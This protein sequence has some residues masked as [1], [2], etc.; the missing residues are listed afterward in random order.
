[1]KKG[2]IYLGLLPMLG[3]CS[4]SK[5]EESKEKTILVATAGDIKPFDYEENGEITGYDAEVLKAVDKKLPDYRI[6]FKRTSWESIFPGLDADHYQAAANN[7]SYTKERADKYL[8]SLPIAKNPLVLVSKSSSGIVK[9]EDIAGK[10]TQDDTGTS[11]AKLVTDWNEEHPKQVS[12]IDYSGEDIAKRLLD[13]ENGEFDY[14][15]FDKISVET[16]VKEYGYELQI[17]ELDTDQNPNN[18][19]VFSKE[20]KDFKDAFD[21][22]VREFYKDGTLEKLSKTYLGGS[23]L[24]DEKDISKN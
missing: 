24:P 4:A 13:L 22:T 1:M 10:R 12:Y 2:W 15:I 21:Q 19:I 6:E 20:N 14:L 11:T 17:K 23:Y 18:Y 8:Y 5:V 7:L 16:I 3:A 9:I